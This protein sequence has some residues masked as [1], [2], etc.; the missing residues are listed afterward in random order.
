MAYVAETLY[1]RVPEKSY[2]EVI[3]KLDI[4]GSFGFCSPNSNVTGS[5][6]TSNKQF[7]GTSRVSRNS[8]L[9]L[10]TQR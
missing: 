5:P 2:R 7:L 9:T 3:I 6:H 4:L 1:R 8:I 10:S